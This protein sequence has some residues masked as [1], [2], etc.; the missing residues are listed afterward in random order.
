[1]LAAMYLRPR[2]NLRGRMPRLRRTEFR[3]IRAARNAVLGVVSL[4]AAAAWG[5]DP[6]NRT[7]KQRASIEDGNGKAQ[8]RAQDV[9]H[10]VVLGDSISQ[11]LG[12]QSQ[13]LSYASLVVDNDDARYPE[14]QGQ[15]LRHLFG[16][17]TRFINLAHEGDT[18]YD[19]IA[20]QLPQLFSLLREEARIHVGGS[21]IEGD[22]VI[23][24]GRLV[25]LLT[26]GGNDLQ[27]A[28]RPN[29][30]FTGSALSR[31]L[32]NLRS[33]MDAVRDRDLF[34]SGADVYFSNVYDLT[35]GEDHL[36]GCMEGMAF[37]GISR[38]LGVWSNSYASLA[39][40]ESARLVDALNLFRG[41]GHNYA[42]PNNPYFDEEDPTLWLYNRDCIHP[43]NL[44]HHMLRRA[45]YQQIERDYGAP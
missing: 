39:Y 1:M 20:R 10:V 36:V 22:R 43:N 4:W 16:P 38:A 25:L 2:T 7:L 42:N 6:D 41:H 5:Q 40:Q 34:Q 29:N 27:E 37:P 12:A 28:L 24:P 11:G 17:Q 44:G 35:D 31:S 32:V 9:S 3:P 45:F 30:D 15:D 8:R 21:Y 23:L 33:V 14:D 18:T 19:V 13:S 26:A